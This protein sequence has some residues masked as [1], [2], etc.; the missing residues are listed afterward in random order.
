[1][2][3]F[4]VSAT[5]WQ[6]SFFS[7]LCEIIKLKGQQDKRGIRNMGIYDE[8][9]NLN[10]NYWMFR[11]ARWAGWHYKL[12]RWILIFLFL[13]IVGVISWSVTHN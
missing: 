8:N 4:Q 9:G 10:E 7:L 11:A 2:H 13:V 3:F 5:N 6:R 12:V 1:M